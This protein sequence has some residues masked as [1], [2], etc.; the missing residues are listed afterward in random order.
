MVPIP[1]GT[2]LM[3]SP[4]D[5]KGRDDNE[6]PQHPVTVKPFWMGEVRG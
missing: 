6:G 2:F 5:E 4:D 3:G 1:G